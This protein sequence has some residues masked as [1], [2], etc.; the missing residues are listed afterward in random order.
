MIKYDVAIHIN[1]KVSQKKSILASIVLLTYT[2]D[3]PLVKSIALI[4][5]LS[6]WFVKLSLLKNVTT[7]F[8]PRT[9]DTNI[10]HV[11][12]YCLKYM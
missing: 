12:Y 7:L 2:I 10:V 11:Y 4:P 8:A 1:L 3:L 9:F 6:Y 5:R